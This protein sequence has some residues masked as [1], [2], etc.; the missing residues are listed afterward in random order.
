VIAAPLHRL[1]LAED[2]I[3]GGAQGFGAVNEEQIIYAP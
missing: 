2:L 1:V 3:D